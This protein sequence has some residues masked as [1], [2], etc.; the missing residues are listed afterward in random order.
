MKE[1]LFRYVMQIDSAVD[2]LRWLSAATV[3]VAW[4]DLSHRRSNIQFRPN[5]LGATRPT[6]I[7]YHK[8][9]AQITTVRL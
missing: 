8:Y 7:K 3:T 4:H 1:V 2:Q 6:E 9:R 5:L